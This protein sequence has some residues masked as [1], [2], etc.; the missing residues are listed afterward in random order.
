MGVVTKYGTGYKDPAALNPADAAFAE[1]TMR[2]ISSKVSIANGDSATSVLYVG[3]VP[4]T[5]LISPDAK[6]FG[7]VLASLTDMS[8]GFKGAPKALMSSVDVSAGGS[9]SAVSNV[10]AGNYVKRAWELAGL[11]SNPGGVLDVFLT[12][13]ANAAGAAD[14]HVYLP[15]MKA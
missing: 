1:G 3:K 2:A 8:L 6:F 13:G 4:A 5:A 15:F 7:P 10:G 11:A 14:C 12:L 9:F